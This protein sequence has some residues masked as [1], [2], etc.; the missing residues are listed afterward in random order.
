MSGYNAKKIYDQCYITEF[1]SQQTN[2]CKYRVFTPFAERIDKC[3]SLNGPRANKARSSGE[4]GNTDITF[5]TD[6]ES[7]LFNLDVPDSRCI[8]LKTMREKNE[9]LNRITQKKKINYE[10]CGKEQDTLYSR[11]DI[12]VNKYKSVYI[13]NQY[14]FPIIDPREFVYYGAEKT[15]QIGNQRFG[16]NTQ[17][18]AKDLISKPNLKPFSL[19][20]N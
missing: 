11:L 16:V 10:L 14:G 3:H 19:L 1:I 7:Q 5:R 4:L 17:L 13:P 18:Q 8:T 9:R 12:P 6:V 20:T 2:P 15:E